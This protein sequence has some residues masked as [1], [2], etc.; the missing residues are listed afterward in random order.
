MTADPNIEALALDFG[1]TPPARL[2]M[3]PIAVGAVLVTSV[4]AL[5]WGIRPGALAGLGDP[6]LWMKC[7]YTAL[8]AGTALALVKVLGKPGAN[9]RLALFALIVTI[10]LAIAIAA[11]VSAIADPTQPLPS[12]L[13]R[14]WTTCS[15]SIFALSMLTT[16]FV[17][18]AA[19]ALAPVRRLAAGAAMGIAGGG[20]AATSYGLLYCA[21]SSPIFIVVWYTLGVAAAGLA[22]AA[23]GKVWIR[24]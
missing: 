6:Q 21:E 11:R 4:V 12:L 14:T 15:V 3:V 17:F 5:F 13:G 2:R 20:I 19:R 8:L 22:G 9:I 7:A 23:M 10:T 1:P 16:P 24:W 18:F